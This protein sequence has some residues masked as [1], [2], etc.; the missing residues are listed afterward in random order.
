M[1]SAVDPQNETEVVSD[2]DLLRLWSLKNENKSLNTET[3]GKSRCGK[4]RTEILNGGNIIKV[5]DS[6]P[7]FCSFIM[8]IEI[9]IVVG[10][11]GM[12]LLNR[13]SCVDKKT[14]RPVSF[15]RRRNFQSLH[16]RA[17]IFRMRNAS[18]DSTALWSEMD[19]VNC[20]DTPPP[21]Y[22]F[23]RNN[24]TRHHQTDW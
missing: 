19:T 4:K 1:V 23:P 21:P 13:F 2:D 22:R 6:I 10:G 9:G 17:S 12:W 15:T 16:N 18:E 14:T 7:S 11:F 24:S 8:G 20:P 5:F 3:N